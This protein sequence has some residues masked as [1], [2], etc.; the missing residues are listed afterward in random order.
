MPGL[1]ICKAFDLLRFCFC[2]RSPGTSPCFSSSLWGLSVPGMGTKP[3]PGSGVFCSGW[4]H[5]NTYSL[6]RGGYRLYHPGPPYRAGPAAK[7]HPHAV[8]ADGRDLQILFQSACFSCFLLNVQPVC[9]LQVNRTEARCKG[10]FGKLVVVVHRVK[11]RQGVAKRLCRR[12]LMPILPRW[13]L[14]CTR[15]DQNRLLLKVTSMRGV[16]SQMSASA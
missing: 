12:E 1:S 9:Q 3:I 2:T 6:C 4:R 5:Q 11:V 13:L 15:V 8:Q 7:A 14:Y 10:I 16:T